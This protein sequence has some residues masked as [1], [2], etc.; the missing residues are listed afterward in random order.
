MALYFTFF[1]YFF[2]LPKSKPF[3]ALTKHS[4]Y[5]SVCHTS[6]SIVI[7]F[8]IHCVFNHWNLQ[9]TL[10][11][12]FFPTDVSYLVFLLVNT[13]TVSRDCLTFS[14]LYGFSTLAFFIHSHKHFFRKSYWISVQRISSAHEIIFIFFQN[15]TFRVPNIFFFRHVHIYYNIFQYFI[16]IIL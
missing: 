11:E 9:P 12:F 15:H 14:S 8:K 3:V 13:S 6:N 5:S 4:A 16:Y 1:F 2:F 10:S 7:P